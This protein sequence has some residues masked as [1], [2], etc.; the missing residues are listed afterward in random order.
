MKKSLLQGVSE[1]DMKAVLNTLTLNAFYF[2]SLMPLKFSPTLTW[3]TLQADK[4]I[5]IAAD[6]VSFNSSAP[7]KSRQVVERLSGDI[8]KILISR[9]KEESDLNEYQQ[10]LH[11]ANTEEG[12]RALVEFVYGDVEF[13]FDGVNARLEWLALRALSTGKITL[14]SSNN[15]GIVTETAVD[16]LVPTANKRGA[17][18]A[19]SDTANAKPIDDIKAIVKLAKRKGGVGFMFMNPDTFDRFKATEQV[20]KFCAS[21]FVKA[22]GLETMPTLETVNQALRGERLPE[23]RI[24]D[25]VIELEKANGDR[26]AVEPWEDGVVTFVQSLVVGNTFHAPL[27]DEIVKDS[28]A[29]KTRRGHVLIKKFSEENP[30]AEHTHGMANAFPV[31][32]SAGRSYLLNTKGTTWTL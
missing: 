26:E 12:Q 17:T 32:S 15:N 10:L 20:I 30:V 4:G 23:I 27:A 6:V 8:P 31:W 21:W 24:I 14:N 25:S 29:T 7:K 11:Y 2:P 1:K 3:K 28:A 19:W 18:A 5:P 9:V 22:T 13:C 16:F